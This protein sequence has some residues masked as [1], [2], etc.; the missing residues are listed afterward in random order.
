MNWAFLLVDL[1][2]FVLYWVLLFAVEVSRSETYAQ[3]RRVFR[4]YLLTMLLWS[5]AAFLL[6]SGIGD[7]SL[8]FRIIHLCL[9]WISPGDLRVC[10]DHP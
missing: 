7:V 3:E 9:A 4:V 5:A 2:A 1:L 6:S 10:K 8:W